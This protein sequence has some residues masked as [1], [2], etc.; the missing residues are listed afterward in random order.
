MC[1]GWVK[2]MK[3]VVNVSFESLI[4]EINTKVK[5]KEMKIQEIGIKV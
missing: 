2:N 3:N 5:T 1:L 4:N